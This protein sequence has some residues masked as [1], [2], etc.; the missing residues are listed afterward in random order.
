M[1]ERIDPRIQIGRGHLKVADLERALGASNR[2]ITWHPSYLAQSPYPKVR[3]QQYRPCW[4]PA[5]IPGRMTAIPA[6]PSAPW[7]ARPSSPG[8]SPGG[9]AEELES[10][11]RRIKRLEAKRCPVPFYLFAFP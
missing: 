10:R 2:L 7:A 8:T 9:D 3:Q 11:P 6:G 5:P 4:L 1:T